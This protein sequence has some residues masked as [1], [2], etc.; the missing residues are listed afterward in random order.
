MRIFTKNQIDDIFQRTKALDG[1]S[2]LTL[3]ERAGEGIA[4]EVCQRWSTDTRVMVFAGWGN[5]GADALVAARIL[6]QKGYN[7]VIFLLNIGGERLSPE[8]RICRDKLIEQ[9]PDAQLNEIIDGFVMPT[10]EKTDLVIDGILGSGFDGIIPRSFSMLARNINQSGAAVL[11]IDLPTGMH[12][13]WNL[14][15]ISNDMVHANLTLAVGFA[16]LAFFINDNAEIIGEYKVLRL[17]LNRQAIRDTPYAY[18]LFTRA[19]ARALLQPRWLDAS[20]ADY[21]SALICAGSYGMMGAA[22]LACRSAMR[23]GAG[24]VTC[25]APRCGYAIM[26]TAN[27]SVMFL[28]DP[29]ETIISEIRLHYDYQAIAIGPGIGTDYIT[30]NALENFLKLQS[31]NRRPIIIDA[32]ALNCISLRPLMLKYIPAMSVITPHA[33]EFDRLFGPQSSC[34]ARLR[35]A[36]E[37]SREYGIVI[38][39]KGRYTAVVRPDGRIYINDSGTPALATAGTGDCLTGVI[40]GLMAQ[41]LAPEFAASIGVYIH[42]V[43]GEISADTHGTFG[44]TAED[45]AGNIGRAIKSIM[46]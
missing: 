26:Q 3:I 23:A 9:A 31:A 34:E 27:P 16:R 41:G 36:I 28:R 38:V 17:G 24:K 35:T 33:G 2:T 25:Y 5:N 37:K 21:G 13:E 6:S 15:S 44:T 45:V 18:Y 8:C 19:D 14:N 43:A 46:E 32:D 12:S 11:S 40:A 20:K 29:H 39:L 30:I 22:V 42:G 10:V 7:T 4:A 1:V